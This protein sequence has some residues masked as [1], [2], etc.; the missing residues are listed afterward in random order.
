MSLNFLTTLKATSTVFT[1]KHQLLVFWLF[2]DKSAET[3][4]EICGVTD[5]SD[6][7]SLFPTA[8]GL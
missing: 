4:D 2:L 7:Y 3:R 8:S 5:K 1:M 6:C